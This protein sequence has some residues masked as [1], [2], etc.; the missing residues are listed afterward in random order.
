MPSGMTITGLTKSSITTQW[1]TGGT[2]TQNIGRMSIIYYDT[3]NSSFKSN[4][5]IQVV[6]TQ[7]LYS[8]NATNLLSGHEYCFAAEVQSFDKAN[9]SAYVCNR[10]SEI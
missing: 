6:S 1:S 3:A 5:S 7:T 9:M 10:T 8:Y 4:T 2:V